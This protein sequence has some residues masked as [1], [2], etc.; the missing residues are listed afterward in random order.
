MKF[1]VEVEK[2]HREVVT[3]H[4]EANCKEDAEMD[5]IDLAL[6]DDHR[7]EYEVLNVFRYN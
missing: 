5:A 1:G 6:G 4:V 3:Y 2:I 7:A